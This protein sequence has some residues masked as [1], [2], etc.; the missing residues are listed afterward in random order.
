[1][2]VVDAA[3]FEEVERYL[4]ALLVPRDAALERAVESAAAAG[5]PPHQVSP[6]EGRLL[7]LLARIHGARR[8][9]EV[10]TLG[11]YST[12]WLARALPPDGSIVT[13]EAEP[14]R[15]ELARANV[16]SAGLGGVVDVRTGAAL[17]VLPTLD[18][19][20]DLVFLDADKPNNP[21]YL[22]WALKLVAR[23]SLI[24][25]DNVV[26]DGAIADV[27][28]ADPSARG[29][30]RFLEMIAAEPRLEAT[31]VQTVGGKG[32]DGFALALVVA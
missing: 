27:S 1:M 18:G 12:M 26:R 31:A 28:T 10:G 20:F 32:H 13:I 19:P 22:E 6:L 4:A 17:E 30:R 5:L 25:A 7:Y 3:R 14:G 11:G 15:A 24:V 2:T 29:I 23:G 8:I 16:A 9:L 21:A